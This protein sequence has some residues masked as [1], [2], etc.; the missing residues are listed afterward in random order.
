[1]LFRKGE[2]VKP[3]QK[4]F[5]G[6]LGNTVNSRLLEYLMALP[7]LDFN[8]TELARQSGVSRQ[9]VTRILQ[10]FLTWKIVRESAHRGNMTYYKI[11]LDSPVVQS[12]YAFN[13]ALISEMYPEIAGPVVTLH[14]RRLGLVSS[15]GRLEILGKTEVVGTTERLDSLPVLKHTEYGKKIVPRKLLRKISIP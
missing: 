3:G 6:L 1:M 11:N 13:E 15:K 10:L 7:K 14:S 12:L 9:S 5:E 2:G 4:P 8:I